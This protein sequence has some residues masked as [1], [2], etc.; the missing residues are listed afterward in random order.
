MRSA[1]ASLERLLEYKSIPQEASH[2]LASDP[3]ADAWPLTGRIE[4]RDLAMRYRAGLPLALQHF[5]A[6]IEARTKV[7]IVGRTGAGKSTLILALFRL[8]ELASG[9][10]RLLQVLIPQLQ[11]RVPP[12]GLRVS[13]WPYGPLHGR[14][15]PEQ[16]ARDHPWNQSKQ[17]DQGTFSSGSKKHVHICNTNRNAISLAPILL[18]P[19]VARALEMSPQLLICFTYGFSTE[20]Q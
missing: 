13:A 6:T 15:H 10:L 11:L 2:N 16:R 5:S 14:T 12:G 20:S 19:R 17:A 9:P 18:C 7:G 1:L 3:A 8:V 4:F